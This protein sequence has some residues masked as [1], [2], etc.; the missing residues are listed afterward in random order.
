LI[1]SFADN[2]EIHVIGAYVEGF[3]D[4]D[5]LAVARAVR[6]ATLAGKQVVIFKNAQSAAGG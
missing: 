2:P 6:K 1:A 4:L 3:K 5:G